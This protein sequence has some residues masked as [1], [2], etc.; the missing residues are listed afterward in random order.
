MMAFDDFILSYVLSTQLFSLVAHTNNKSIA[1]QSLTLH[2]L[3]VQNSLQI[4]QRRPKNHSTPK[5]T[6]HFLVILYKMEWLFMSTL[7]NTYMHDD[8]VVHLN[9]PTTQCTKR[10][11]QNV[12][13]VEIWIPLLLARIKRDKRNKTGNK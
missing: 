5:Q 11:S 2:I 4:C 8:D 12:P 3:Q 10:N 9:K 7:T 1:S 13:L 6:L